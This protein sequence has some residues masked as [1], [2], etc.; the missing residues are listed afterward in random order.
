MPD[1]KMM[2]CESFVVGRKTGAVCLPF[3]GTQGKKKG[4]VQRKFLIS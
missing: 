2:N 3:L 1:E 4:G